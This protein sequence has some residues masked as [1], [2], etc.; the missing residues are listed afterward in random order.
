MLRSKFFTAALVA[1]T[2]LLAAPAASQATFTLKLSQTGGVPPA[3]LTITDGTLPDP[4]ADGLIQV[5]GGFGDFSTTLTAASSNSA[6][7]SLPATMALTQLVLH[8]NSTGTRTLTLTI[9]DTAFTVPTGPKSLDNSLAWSVPTT[10]DAV[11]TVTLQTTVNGV[12]APLLVVNSSTPNF[13]AQGFSNFGPTGGSYPVQMVVTITLAGGATFNG[14]A[15]ATIT[16][17]TPAPAGVV[18]VASVLPFVAL[19]RRRLR[20]S[21]VATAA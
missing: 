18:L 14:S 7:N 8:N 6:T 5:T 10:Q 12:N 4:A 9:L 20:K 21:D 16:A 19:L 17:T 11:T 1:A 15:G 2:A 3:D 13:G